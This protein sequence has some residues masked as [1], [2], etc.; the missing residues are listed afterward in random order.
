M[1]VKNI[2]FSGFAAAMFAGVMTGADA[3]TYNL[4]SKNYVDTQVAKKQDALVA[5]T[6]IDISTNSKGE[7]E[8]TATVD[9][10]EVIGELKDADGQTITVQ[11]ALAEKQDKLTEANATGAVTITESATGATLIDVDLSNYATAA[12]VP[13]KVSDLENDS[14]F[15]TENE[16]STAIQNATSGLESTSNK[17]V[18]TE[19]DA[20]KLNKMTVE[21]KSSK[22]PSVGAAMAI[23]T[24]MVG[25]I[26]EEV[27]DLTG[28]KTDLQTLQNTVGDET[29]GLVKDVDALETTVGDDTDGLVKDVAD[30]KNADYISGTSIEQAEGGYLVYSDGQGNLTFSSVAIV[31]EDGKTDLITGDDIPAV[32]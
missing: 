4:A 27:G 28:L 14:G 22:Y 6:G 24:A 16:V 10:G 17:F 7:Q 18:D 2:M 26:S 25:E 31:G 30:L 29:G 3:A 19:L 32:E 1:K 13:K 23:A 11:E 20:T 21:E 9:L 8:I 15:Q 12:D 5:G